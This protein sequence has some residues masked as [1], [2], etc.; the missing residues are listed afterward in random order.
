MKKP[1]PPALIAAA[2]LLAL[3]TFWGLGGTPGFFLFV[4]LVAPFFDAALLSARRH[5]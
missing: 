1:A 4:G 2:S 3:G 5:G